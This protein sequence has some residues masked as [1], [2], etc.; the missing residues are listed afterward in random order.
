VRRLGLFRSIQERVVTREGTV[1]AVPADVWRLVSDPSRVPQWWPR[2]RL[3]EVVSGEEAGRLQRVVLAWGRR[4]GVVEQ[5]VTVWEP[6]RR[7]AWRVTRE[8]VGGQE[9]PHVVEVQISIEIA[10]HGPITKVRA[11]GSYR[12]LGTQGVVASRQ[13]SKLARKTFARAIRNVEA[14]LAP[15]SGS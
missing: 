11:V 1:A 3:G 2:A 10:P 4:E 15:R 7:Y 14:A 12:P 13:R 8:A 5:Q 6:P 9:L